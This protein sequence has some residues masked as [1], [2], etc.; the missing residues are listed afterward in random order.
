MRKYGICRIILLSFLLIIQFNISAYAVS[1][2]ALEAD[3]LA[4]VKEEPIQNSDYVSLAH[5][6]FQNHLIDN[7]SSLKKE[8]ENASGPIRIYLTSDIEVPAD[9][10][11]IQIKHP[12]ILTS[13]DGVK[14]I[15]RQEGAN[16]SFFDVLPDSSFMLYQVALDGGRVDTQGTLINVKSSGF[17]E[18]AEGAILRNNHRLSGKG[19][20]V[21]SQGR[22][23]ISG[24]HV[25]NN[26]TSNEGGGFYLEGPYASF[27][28]TNGKVGKYPLEQNKAQSGAGIYAAQTSAAGVRIEGGEVIGNSTQLFY[29][30]QEQRHIR[31]HG[32][33]LWIGEDASAI[34][35][36]GIFSHNSAV[37]GGVIYSQGSLFI[38]DNAN[39]IDNS[40]SEG[41]GV[42]CEGM[43][44]MSGGHI[45]K[46][47]A[48]INGGGV[49]INGNGNFIFKGG[50]IGNDEN[51]QNSS[52]KGGGIYNAS[53]HPEGL[54]ITENAILISN[55]AGRANKTSALGGGIYNKGNVKMTGGLI[56][57]NKALSGYDLNGNKFSGYGGGIY[58]AEGATFLFT[59]GLIGKLNDVGSSNTAEYGAG[60]Y[61]DS[62]VK[63]AVVMG[64]NAYISGNV[65]EKSGAGIF[66]AGSTETKQG[67]WIYGGSITNNSCISTYASYP[68]GVGLEIRGSADLGSC[69]ISNNT[70]DFGSNIYLWRGSTL[71]LSGKPQV[72]NGGIWA[73][74][75][76]PY[77][78]Y[79][80]I[81]ETLEDGSDIIILNAEKIPNNFA[82]AKKTGETLTPQ[83]AE[84]FHTEDGA[85]IGVK[86][87]S[88]ETS[89]HI[90]LCSSALPR[91]SAVTQIQEDAFNGRI[92][93]TFSQSMRKDGNAK[94]VSDSALSQKEPW[95]WTPGREGIELT[96]PYE[97][98]EM[99][100]EYSL[101]VNFFSSEKDWIKLI[102]YQSFMFTTP[103]STCTVSFDAQNGEPYS[104]QKVNLSA[105]V[106]SPKI[107]VRAGYDFLG[108]Y[109]DKNGTV[110]WDFKTDTVTNHLTLY[111]KWE[112]SVV[113][114][115]NVYF[116]YQNGQSDSEMEV[117]KDSKIMQPL[118][119]TFL[120][121]EFLGWYEDDTYTRLWDFKSNL[122]VKDMTLYAGWKKNPNPVEA[123]EPPEPSQPTDTDKPTN[124]PTP[125]S[126]TD[127]DKPVNP[128][129]PTSP[130]VPPKMAVTSLTLNMQYK[131][132][133]P[134]GKV[135]LKPKVLPINATLK[136]VKWKSNKPSVAKVNQKGNVVAGKKKGTATITATVDNKSAK[137]KIIVCKNKTDAKQRSIRKLQLND[138]EKIML[139]QK[140][141]KR[142][143]SITLKARTVPATADYRKQIRFHSKNPQIASVNQKGK[144]SAGKKVGIT[145]VYATT[146]EGGKQTKIKVVVIK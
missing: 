43:F 88:R 26:Q 37:N 87:T 40:A 86:G 7:Y 139:S 21:Y 50:E 111:A 114:K 15:V 113:Q 83:E 121:Y 133:A 10:A 123:V 6:G 5:S 119:P 90:I 132:L 54:H 81:D 9:N 80:E 122:V 22:I 68:A 35:T 93:I 59:D 74:Y 97:N 27:Y 102:P 129:T 72:V 63:H 104:F 49:C 125:T 44:T 120:G 19:G 79:L 115:Y 70:A 108:W 99:G 77:Q 42:Y 95:Y 36:G 109:R 136:K 28:M 23:F 78:T 8:I 20:A 75:H 61:N 57:G 98:L 13:A 65:A 69:F 140:G 71:R 106:I 25:Y 14:T 142:P 29:D 60:I 4:E 144:V 47:F 30:E 127:T 145:Y 118:P 67:L 131:I 100:T 58:N 33:G 105:K 18:I 32:G 17:L 84:A 143:K 141:K 2:N 41:A 91:V 11:S 3:A 134:K 137:C 66:H 92:L 34:L 135:T 38:S 124:P 112:K 103:D 146:K 64:D 89:N 138:K 24:G 116:C 12:V 73:D 110:S 39:L 82:I 94:L 46:N 56:A 51:M 1:F 62:S 52:P 76:Y 101:E 55:Q 53:I 126:P 107:P 45:Y 117:F 130:S 85:L 128:S 48:T 16:E 96:I 31:K